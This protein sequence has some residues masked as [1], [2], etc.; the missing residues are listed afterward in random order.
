M[1]ATPRFEVTLAYMAKWLHPEL[2]SDLDPQ[3][4]H[5]EYLTDFL[6]ID[7]DLSEHGVFVYPEP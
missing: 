3:A 6:G 2:F 5:Q 7:Y 4:I 1:S